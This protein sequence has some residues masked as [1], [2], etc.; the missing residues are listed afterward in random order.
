ME[1]IGVTSGREPSVVRPE[2]SAHVFVTIDGTREAH[3]RDRDT[4]LRITLAANQAGRLWRML[5]EVL[6][7]DEKAAV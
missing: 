1:V 3:V 7:E 2:G 6:S 5:S 4:R